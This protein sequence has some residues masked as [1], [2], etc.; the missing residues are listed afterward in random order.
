MEKS[1][2]I[3]IV[4]Y[5]GEKYQNDCIDSILKSKYDNYKIIIVDN[6]STDNSMKM[7]DSYKTDKIIKIYNNDNYGVAKGNNIGINKSI[8]L[9]CEY[10]LLLNNDTILNDNVIPELI[11]NTINYDVIVPKIYFWSTNKIWY[12]GGSFVRLKCINKHLHFNQEDNG[13]KYKKEYSYAPTCCMLIKNSIFKK[14][15]FMDENYF[16][17]FDDTDFCFRLKLAGIKIGFINNAFIYHKVSLSTGGSKSKISVYYE[18]RNRFYFRKKFN[19]YFGIFSF[20]YIWS[21]RKIKYCLGT[22]KKNNSIIIKK[23]MKDFKNK[24]M[25][26]SD[27]L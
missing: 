22:M 6:K 20:L 9:G 2:G 7:L 13:I 27:D 18:N 17:Y 11:K 3:V 16:I 1:I 21:T 5:N 19:K 14:I 12:G 23:A 26:R 25:G 24:K 15:G 4:N 10:T 8:E